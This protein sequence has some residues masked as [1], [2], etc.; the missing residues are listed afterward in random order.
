MEIIDRVKEK[1][2]TEVS[3]IEKRTDLTKEQKIEKICIVFGTFC[4]ALA[5]QP[6]PFADIFL[7]TPIQAYMGKKIADIH[8]YNITE[9]GATSI[10]KEI[11]GLIG[12]GLLSQQLAIGAYKTFIPFL[13]AITTIPLVFGLTYG[14]G[15]VM[16]AYFKAKI[17]GE[18]ISKEHIRDIF[19]NAKKEGQKM[20]KENEQGIKRAAQDFPLE[21]DTTLA[22][23]SI[24]GKDVSDADKDFKAVE[25][26][27]DAKSDALR[28]RVAEFKKN[29]A[30]KKVEARAMQ[31]RTSEAEREFEDPNNG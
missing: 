21:K 4:G 25:A 24:T 1:I 13:G 28:A 5:A 2:R 3:E 15:K 26:S 10:V 14:M 16:N 12:M 22:S 8:G 19:K 27:I 18:A 17:K 31:G 23:N 7:L 20:G 11:A 29:L 6:I 9:Q 30:A